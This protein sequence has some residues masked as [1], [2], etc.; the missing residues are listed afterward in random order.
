MVVED[1]PEVRATVS[2]MLQLG[3]FHV[4]QVGSGSEALEQLTK[5][6][7]VGLVL[8]DVIMPGMS[9]FELA[10]EMLERGITAPLALISGY[11][12]GK[13][14]GTSGDE[15]LPFISKPFSLA[16]LLEFV[17]QHVR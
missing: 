8:S 9:G 6:D 3:G 15:T 13:S 1:D 5:D 4:M 7:T 14:A 12:A 10:G 2:E 16:Q 17:Q 11:A